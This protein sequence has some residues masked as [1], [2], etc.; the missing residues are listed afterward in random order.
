MRLNLSFLHFLTNKGEYRMT[1]DDLSAA[2]RKTFAD[3]HEVSVTD[4]FF[5]PF[6]EKI[7][8]VTVQDIFQK[9]M[10]DG[11]IENYERVARGERGGH[12][13][14]PWYHG[15]ICEVI[16]GVSDLLAAHYDPALDEQLDTIIDAIRRAQSDDGWLH[17]FDTLERPDQVFGLNG[18]NA[19]YQHEIYDCGCLVEAGVHHYLST[20]KTSLLS[21][22]VKIANYL[23]DR[24]G[25]APKWNIACEHSLAESAMISLEQLF[26]KEPSLAAELGAKRGEYLRLAKFWYDH[27]GDNETRH[28][29]P[30]FLQE[31]A[32][33]HRPAREQRE[34]VGHAVRATLCYAGMA[35]CAMAT[36]DTELAKAALAIW[37]D[38]VTTK[39]HINGSVGA[40]RDNERFGQQYELPN[41]AYLETCAGVGLLFFAVSVFQLTGEAS[42]WD[43]AEN[44]I[45]NLLPASV[46]EDGVRYTYE[47]P[48]ESKGGR[49]RWSWHPCPCC[50][51]MLLKAAGILPSYIFASAENSLYV[52]LYIDATAK[53][54]DAVLTLTSAESGKNLHIS[55]SGTPKQL[56]LRIPEWA[57]DFNLNLPYTVERGY[58]V[59]DLPAGES[60]VEIRYAAK[61]VKVAAHPWVHADDGRVAV[62]YGPV[63]YCLEGDNWEAMDPVLS[64]EEPR[65]QEDGSITVTTED[66]QSV[67]LIEYRRWNNHGALPMRVWLRQSGYAADPRDCAGWEDRLYREYPFA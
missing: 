32:Q 14:P 8:T 27:K 64:D 45:V 37:Q 41:D 61:P 44:T 38:I 54:G 57:H 46:S 1:A 36:G 33:D 21:C 11:A 66:G 43:T 42:V 58:A 18:G 28:Q 56:R 50:P 3:L 15:L 26:E 65:L 12:A 16:R 34:A 2:K 22:S 47:N 4:P 55:S 59:V 40:H 31:Y 25:D 17:P 19:R 39:L 24:I 62:K 9:F 30:R 60:T 53:I 52:N 29:F 10:K 7:R 51:P 5:A 49:E 63:L 67:R 13:G 48:L 35:D 6:L 23:A 20:G